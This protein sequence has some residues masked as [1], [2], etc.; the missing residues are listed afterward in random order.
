MIIPTVPE[1]TATPRRTQRTC[2]VIGCELPHRTKGWCSSHYA[3]WRRTGSVGTTPIRPTRKFGEQPRYAGAHYRVRTRRGP[4]GAQKCTDCGAPAYEW[5]YD[6]TDPA[7]LTDRLS[8][9]V[10]VR[11]STDPEYYVPLCRSC[12]RRRDHSRRLDIAH[13]TALYIEH[14]SVHAVAAAIG[15]HSASIARALRTAGV[16]MRAPGRP[17][18]SGTCLHYHLLVA[19]NLV[20]SA[21]KRQCLACQRANSNANDAHRRRGE[22]WTVEQRQAAADAHYERIMAAA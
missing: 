20:P 5:A 3:R 15:G 13:L 6:H 22:T 17:E 18:G 14:R 11:Y 12:H 21:R 16:E 10:E 8:T 2:E 9:G 1:S 7:E 4:A 19:P